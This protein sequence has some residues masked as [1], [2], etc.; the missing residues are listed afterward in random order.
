[1]SKVPA[2]VKSKIIGKDT[3][4]CLRCFGE[5]TAASEEREGCMLKKIM[6]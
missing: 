6:D 3:Y 2:R 4:N 5:H 1:M